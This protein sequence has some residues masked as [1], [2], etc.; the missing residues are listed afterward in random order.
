MLLVR[1]SNHRVA[2]WHAHLA[3][4]TEE[5]PN[6]QLPA[7]AMSAAVATVAAGWERLGTGKAA[8]AEHSSRLSSAGQALDAFDAAVTSHMIV[9]TASTFR[10]RGA[11]CTQVAGVEGKL[12]FVAGSAR[13]LFPVI[14]AS[15]TT[16]TLKAG[17]PLQKNCSSATRV[18]D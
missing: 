16:A 4:A 18:T 1:S 8:E 10:S 17:P 3:Y 2:A 5:K 13:G 6:A 7:Q 9:A 15:I 14:Q 11:H 12:G